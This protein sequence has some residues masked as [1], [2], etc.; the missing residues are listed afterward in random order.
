MEVEVWGGEDAKNLKLLTKLKPKLPLEGEL[1]SLQ[2]L[3]G[4]FKSKKVSC[5][6]I[7]AKPNFKLNP[8]S[9]GKSN[10]KNKGKDKKKK[11]GKPKAL[12]LIDEM[13]LN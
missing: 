6:K 8:K 1:H 12:L 11:K 7:I 4:L 13:F 2:F 9:K 3:E 5:I 10:A